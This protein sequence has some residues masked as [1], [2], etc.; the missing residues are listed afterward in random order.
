V[1]EP[2]DSEDTPSAYLT[3]DQVAALKAASPGV[4]LYALD[5]PDDGVAVV[6]RAPTEVEYR[7]LINGKLDRAADRS[8]VLAQLAIKLVVAPGTDELATLFKLYPALASRI[9]GQAMAIAAGEGAATAKK[10]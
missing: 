5:V 10:L 9:A 7:P 3:R 4:R 2:I 8:T 6:F 1:T